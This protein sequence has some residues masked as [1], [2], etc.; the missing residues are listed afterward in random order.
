MLER[1]MKHDHIV[2]APNLVYRQL[3]NFQAVSIIYVF[4][5]KRINPKQIMDA[6]FL[7]R[8]QERPGATA[9]IK[10]SEIWA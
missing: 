4:I 10:N 9:N 8:L 2:L 6:C 7:K 5:N 1:V 3:F